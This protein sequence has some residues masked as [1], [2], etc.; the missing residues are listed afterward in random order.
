L[1]IHLVLQLAL[2]SPLYRAE[3]VGVYR[4]PPPAS[5]AIPEEAIA[6]HAAAGSLFGNTPMPIGEY[7]SPDPRWLERQ[8]FNEAYPFVGMMARRRFE[9]QLSPEGLDSFFTRATTHAFPMLSEPQ[10]IRLLEAS[11]AEWL[12]TKRELAPF[13]G[14]EL[15]QR[16]PSLGG[17]LLLYRLAG[18]AAPVQFVGETIFSETLNDALAA[19]TSA[20]FRPREQVVIAGSGSAGSGAKGSVETITMENSETPEASSWRVKAEGSGVLLIQKTY[21]PIYRVEVDGAAVTPWLANMHRIAVPIEAGEHVV[22]LWPDRTP[23]R[24][25]AAVA[26]LTA[27]GLVLYVSTTLAS[28]ARPRLG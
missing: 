1:A 28:G 18:S 10:R 17:D 3:P 26:L 23:F 7:P 16:F 11:A 4:F 6:V 21:L 13:E 19:L 25:S 2:L 24:L 5:L 12:Y 22:R 8:V 27:L 14:I 9:F 15:V 20:E